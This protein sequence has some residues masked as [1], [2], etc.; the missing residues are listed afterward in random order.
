MSFTYNSDG[1]RTSK[2]VNGVTTTYYLDG[3]KIVGEETNGNI[4]LYFYDSLGL[5]IGFQYHAST[6]ASGVYDIYWYEKNLQGDIVAIYNQAGTKIV[7]YYYDAW[8]ACYTTNVVS[9]VP[10]VVTNNPFRY[11][12]YY[13]DNDLGL[14]YL[15]SRY[16]DHNTGRFISADAQLN[17]STLIGYNL[18][19]YCDNNPIIYYDPTGRSILGIVGLI[20]V[21]AMMI[22][23]LTGSEY[24]ADVEEPINP[25]EPPPPE[26]GYLPPKK[27]PNPGKVKNPNGPGRGW[28]DNEGGVWIPD[29][30][31]DGGPGWVQQFPGGKHKHRYPNGSVRT[32]NI[33]TENTEEIVFGG[34]IMVFSGALIIILIADNATGVGVADDTLLPSLIGGFVKGVEMVGG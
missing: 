22:L 11:R 33:S 32:H 20:A 16:Y 26:S 19:A 15:N 1:I 9:S 34:L 28:P 3:S 10:S 12:G 25:Q 7:S 4:T 18:Y 23:G 2:T 29:N 31:Q 5:P 14:Y 21:S 27:N 13:Y 8:G 30:N 17:C 24:K 6:Y